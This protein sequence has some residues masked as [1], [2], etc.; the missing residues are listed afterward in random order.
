MRSFWNQIPLL[1]ITQAVIAGIGAEIFA[2]SVLHFSEQTMILFSILLIV[3]FLLII[4][5]NF[6]NKVELAYRLR[7]VNGISLSVFLISFGYI[8][9]WLYADKNYQTHFQK[10]ISPDS[11]LSNPFSKIYFPR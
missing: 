10:F 7:I 5:L 3:S 4:A 9:T 6:V 2:D 11:K 1:R 8:L